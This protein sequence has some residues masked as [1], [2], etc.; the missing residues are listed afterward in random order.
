MLLRDGGKGDEDMSY[1]SHIKQNVVADSNNTSGSNLTS[2]NGYTFSGSSTSTLG[3]VGLQWSL[4]T[5]Q[6]ATVYVEQSPDDIN[7][8]ISYNYNY[9]ASFGGQGETVQATQSYWRIRVVLTTSIDTTYFRLQGVLCPIATPLPSSLS[10][11]SRLKTESTFVGRENTDRHVWVSPTNSFGT[12]TPTRLVGSNFDGTTKDP[13]FWTPTITNSGSVTQSGEIEL[14]TS[15]TANGTAKYVSVRKARFVVGSGLQFFGAFAF[16]TAGTT[17]NVR[18]CGAYDANEGFFFELDGDVFSVGSRKTTSDTLISSGS[19]NGNYGST[20]T[21]TSGEVYYKLTIE[22]TPLGA[23]YYVNGKLLHK[24]VG[25]HLTTKL[26]LP[27]TFENVNDNDLAEEI[28]FDCLGVVIMREGQLSTNP[29]SKYIGTATTNVLKYG[30]GSLH[31]VTITDNVGTL[32]LYDGVSAS[33]LLLA[34]IDASK[35]VGTMEFGLP[36]STGLTAVSA[37]SSIKM[38]VVYE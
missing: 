35:T 17:D 26:T 14:N 29:T 2:A 10:D 33:G 21:P 23:F 25:G 36:F 13:N 38:T 30:A 27:I 4:K 5:D 19:F 1:F 3:V 8:D 28:I 12:Y 31:R 15:A 16:V 22:W 6:N 7:W 32:L 11:D 24:S 34:N 37:N 9:I 20:F 18:R